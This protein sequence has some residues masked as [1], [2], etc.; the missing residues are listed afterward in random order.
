MSKKQSTTTKAIAALGMAMT[1]GSGTTTAAPVVAQG[2]NTVQQSSAR[3]ERTA[4]PAQSQA[5]AAY[6]VQMLDPT[7]G[8]GFYGG[9]SRNPWDAPR[10]NQRKGRKA[11]RQAGS[12]SRQVARSR[13]RKAGN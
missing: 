2:P 10:Y 1:L 6:G 8:A 13:G 9:I 11:I 4:L 12:R 5:R 3:S 7:G